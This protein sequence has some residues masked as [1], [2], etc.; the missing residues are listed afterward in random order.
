MIQEYPKTPNEKISV[1]LELANRLPTSVT[2]SSGTAAAIDV[3]DGTNATTT[4]L[5]SATG[6]VSGSTVT[7]ILQAGTTGH[8]YAI[9]CLVTLSNSDI[10]EEMVIL[11]VKA[12]VIGH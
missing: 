3:A 9:T 10:L 11:R 12:N 8:T 7:W 6:A 2:I 5:S 4:V 1:A